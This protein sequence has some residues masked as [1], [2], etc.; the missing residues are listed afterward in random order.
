MTDKSSKEI[1]V[2]LDFAYPN[3]QM[4]GC[5][6]GYCVVCGR[7]IDVDTKDPSEK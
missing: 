5:V 3:D 1:N 4:S 6:L 2:V 7:G